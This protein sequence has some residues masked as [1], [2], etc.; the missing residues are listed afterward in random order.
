M[1]AWHSYSGL[2]FRRHS[3]SGGPDHAPSRLSRPFR[4]VIPDQPVRVE[5]LCAVA[6]VEGASACIVRQNVDADSPS[7]LSRKPQCEPAKE[8]SCDPASTVRCSDPEILQLALAIVS[9]REVP[10]DVAKHHLT[11]HRNKGGARRHAR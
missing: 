7:P 3:Y 1:N 9:L 6:H 4:D 8:L 2:L 10:S 5:L 11:S